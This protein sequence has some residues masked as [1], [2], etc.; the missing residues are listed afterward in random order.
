MQCCARE[1]PGA[2]VGATE[3][4]VHP[5]ASI[6]PGVALDVVQVGVEVV[7]AARASARLG[8]VEESLECVGTRQD[9]AARLRG[10]A[11]ECGS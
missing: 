4:P 1:P 10:N 9:R 11:G 8:G 3:R 7:G 2:A 5:Q 6:L